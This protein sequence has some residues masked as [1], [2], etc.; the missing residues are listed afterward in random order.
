MEEC[1][2]TKWINDD[3]P[4]NQCDCE[5]VPEN[6]IVQDYQI[7]DLTSG[8][9]YNNENEADQIFEVNSLGISCFNRDQENCC[10]EN[11]TLSGSVMGPQPLPRGCC[12]DY[13]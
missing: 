5:A 1:E 2:W 10:P 6:C 3:G 13:R 11:C 12:R 4:A 7:K 9:I 8:T